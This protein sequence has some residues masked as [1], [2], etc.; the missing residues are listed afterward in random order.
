MSS[1]E[2]TIKAFR[3]LYGQNILVSLTDSKVLQKEFVSTGSIGLNKALSGGLV[4]GRTV[5]VFGPESAG[6][7]SLSL[8]MMAEHQKVGKVVLIDLEHAF[9]VNY[10][11]KLGVNVNDIIFSQPSYAEQAF[12]LTE[13]LAA[14]G[15]VSL[16]VIDSIAA[17]SP[18]AEMIGDAGDSNMG[19]IAR[20]MGQ[21]LR[22]VTSIASQNNCTILYINQ[23]RS[24]LGV[25]Y[26]PK[27][28]TP[29]G[30]ALKFFTSIR[31]EIKRIKTLENG[32]IS[33]IRVVKNKTAVP[34][35]EAVFTIVFGEG[36]DYLLEIVDL[37]IE[38][39]LIIKKG[40]W[41]YYNDINLGQGTEKVKIYL[42]ENE[43]TLKEIKDKISI[44]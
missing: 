35:K 31:M 39:K 9:D 1:L 22:K 10:A 25:M 13:H 34:F 27:T 18:K 32:I 2:E 16:I 30:K 21:H 26:G 36:I 23:V 29:G 44:Y 17:L 11:E 12:E 28:V 33:K 24:N 41:F 19:L 40:T 14:T 38:E 3:K 20:L 37:A 6:K 42:K 15:V 4:R 43:E 7:S 8:H 5:E